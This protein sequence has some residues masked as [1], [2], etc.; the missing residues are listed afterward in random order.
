M[1]YRGHPS[2]YTDA[3]HRTWGSD[4]THAL[5]TCGEHF[6]VTLYLEYPQRDSC[7]IAEFISAYCRFTGENI[8]DIN[9]QRSRKRNR[10]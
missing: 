2:E 4:G 9:I 5:H 3:P 7:D 10:E 6:A 1:Q 8:E